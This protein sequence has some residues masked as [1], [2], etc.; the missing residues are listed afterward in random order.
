MFLRLYCKFGSLLFPTLSYAVMQRCCD[1]RRTGWSCMHTTTQ[2]LRTET[3]R[4]GGH[5]G[6]R[7]IPYVELLASALSGVVR[8]QGTAR[9]AQP[10]TCLV[11]RQACTS[12]ITKQQL[13][14]I[15]G[16]VLVPFHV[17]CVI[18][19]ARSRH[20]ASACSV[21]GTGPLQL[22]KHAVNYPAALAAQSDKGRC[23][24]LCLPTAAHAFPYSGC[25]V[26]L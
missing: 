3:L 12:L 25:P 13:R 4:D 14:Q 9:V 8:A 26:L 18:G 1:A 23:H 15:N 7:Y 10:A 21:R 22:L 5:G 24:N 19:C 6:I 16:I 11:R 20:T 2:P 17:C